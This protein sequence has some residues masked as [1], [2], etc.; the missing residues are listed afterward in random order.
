MFRLSSISSNIKIATLLI[1][2]AISSCD[3]EL[4]SYSDLEVIIYN[5]SFA[6]IKLYKDNKLTGNQDYDSDYG[7]VHFSPLASGNYLIEATAGKKKKAQTFS[8]TTGQKTIEF[9]F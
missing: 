9:S 3:S 5:S 6:N 8:Y 7:S 1:F 4:S 2:T